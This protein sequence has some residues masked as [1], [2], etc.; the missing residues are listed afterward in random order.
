[1]VVQSSPATA[2]S[3]FMEATKMVKLVA[4]TE[5][6]WTYRHGDELE[7]ST[8]LPHIQIMCYLLLVIKIS[9]RKLQILNNFVNRGL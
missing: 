6:C 2:P 3:P 1:M 8:V 5:T 9:Y 7:I 4:K